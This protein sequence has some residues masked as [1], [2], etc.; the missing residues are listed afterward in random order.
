MTRALESSW[1]RS[2]PCRAQV[3]SAW[4]RL[5]QDS[6]NEAMASQAT[7]TDRSRD[8]QSVLPQV[9]QMELID[10]VTWC[11]RVTRT[12]PAQKNASMARCQDQTPLEVQ[13]PPITAGASSVN[14]MIPGNQASTRRIF[15]SASRSGAN[16][17]CE[18]WL[19]SNSHSV[20]AQSRPLASARALSPYRQGECG[21]PSLSLYLWCRLW[22]A[23]QVSTGPCIARLPAIASATRRPGLALNELW[24]K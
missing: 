4:C 10:Q 3:G 7:L 2:A 8:T 22:S 13:K 12:R 15:R 24:V 1:P 6:P 11:S 20:C 9:W 21:S 18:V 17:C 23:T 16:F 19:G 5:C 14:A